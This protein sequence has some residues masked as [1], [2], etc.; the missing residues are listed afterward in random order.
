MS[1]VVV[2]N[3]GKSVPTFVADRRERSSLAKRL[4]GSGGGGI[5]RL[6][7]KAGVFRLMAGGKEIAAIDDRHLDVVIVAA[8]DA[9]SRT[10]YSGQYVE[11]VASAPSCWSADGTVPNEKAA[12]PQASSC[13]ACPQNQKGSGQG[14]SRACRFS[15]RIALL[16]ASDIEGDVMEMTVPATSLFGKEQGEDRPL[17][18]YARWLDASN[19]DPEMVV[20]RM[21]FDTKASG[22]KLFF[23][24]ARWLSE[25]EHATAV[26]KG[27][28]E[29]AKRAITMTVAQVDAVKDT[30]APAPEPILEGKRPSPKKAKPKEEE[31]VA[32]AEYVET[33]KEPAV[34][35]SAPTQVRSAT[36]A[37]AVS[38]WDDDE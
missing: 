18:S 6:S 10:Y 17:Q 2:F 37:K 14:D 9:I 33:E 4:A 19:I 1:D 27:Q 29:D 31:E 8:A 5:K 16:L 26:E 28:S 34:R 7:I 23:R 32:E 22:P 36:L 20:T 15:Q 25:D 12:D 35:K 24:A 13:A 38:D 11:G 21:R 3:P 30:H